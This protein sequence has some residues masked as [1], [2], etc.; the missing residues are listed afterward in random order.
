MKLILRK[1]VSS[2]PS[3]L[4]SCGYSLSS[5]WTFNLTVFIETSVYQLFEMMRVFSCDLAFGGDCW[6]NVSL[7]QLIFNNSQC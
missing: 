7:A 3:P 6:I 5:R 1:T 4:C 2:R